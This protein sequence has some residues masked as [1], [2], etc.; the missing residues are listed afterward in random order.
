[1][2]YE[3]LNGLLV[4][5]PCFLMGCTF[6]KFNLF[7]KIKKIFIENRL[8]NIIV[9]IVIGLSVF[10]I[11]Y[12][13]GNDY[14]Y[15]YLLAP[16]FYISAINIVKLLRSNNIFTCLGKHSANMWLIH[17]FFCY[18]YFQRIVYYPKVAIIILIW[19]LLLSLECSV[20]I[21]FL[22]KKC[23][24]LVAKLKF[25]NGISKD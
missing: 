21:E 23:I 10:L 8:D 4:W 11:R 15:D 1:M 2:F 24:S 18:Q 3:E 17:S 5:L 19:L 14:S 7:A 12:R 9:Y 25:N 20:A 13:N 22:S 16:V 6:S